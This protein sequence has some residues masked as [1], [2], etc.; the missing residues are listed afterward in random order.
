MTV[1][2]EHPQ[3]SVYRNQRAFAYSFD[4]SGTIPD[5]GAY[6]VPLPQHTTRRRVCHG[7]T[8]KLVGGDFARC[9]VCRAPFVC[10]GS[11]M[12]RRTRWIR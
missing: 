4:T 5:R 12:F 10:I 1:P 3:S 6:R 9:R 11:G 7:K 2:V 8:G